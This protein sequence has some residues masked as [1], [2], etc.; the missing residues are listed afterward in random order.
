[1]KLS[2]ITFPECPLRSWDKFVNSLSF[3]YLMLLGR[4]STCNFELFLCPILMYLDPICVLVIS[5]CIILYS[6]TFAGSYQ[7]SKY[8]YRSSFCQPIYTISIACDGNAIAK[9]FIFIQQQGTFGMKAYQNLSLFYVSL[10]LKSRIGMSDSFSG[11]MRV[12]KK[13]LKMSA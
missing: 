7:L 9:V 4:T 12:W 1:M 8:C 6:T 2:L 10:I 11:N 13:A 3:F 5:K